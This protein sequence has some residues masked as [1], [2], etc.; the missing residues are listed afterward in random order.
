MRRINVR[1]ARIRRLIGRAPLVRR[2]AVP[3]YAGRLL[4]AGRPWADVE[5][6]FRLLAADSR[7]TLIAGP[8]AGG[9]S[10]ELLYW[11]PFLRWAI[12]SHRIDPARV[13]AVSP[14]GAASWYDGLCAT[15]VSGNEPGVRG[16]RIDAKALLGH[17]DR[18]RDGRDAL[19]PILRH[20][21]QRRLVPAETTRPSRR[22]VCVACAGTS[23]DGR[24]AIE[25]VAETLRNRFEIV[26][27]DTI[28]RDTPGSTAEAVSAAISRADGVFA[29]LSTLAYLGQLYGIPTI[30]IEGAEPSANRA[31]EEVGRRAGRELESPATILTPSQL[32][33]L[34]E[35]L[36][37]V[38][39]QSREAQGQSGHQ[40]DSPL[41]ERL[42]DTNP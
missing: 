17:V 31:D 35:L 16:V 3:W 15:F 34:L 7:L 25:H 5:R 28:S 14:S 8:W 24:A 1:S 22:Y 2:L 40:L 19:R 32:S 21:R 6:A 11:I 38:T 27:L 12:E 33:T 4:A 20:A 36:P 26:S 29:P 13:V 18:Y 23:D 9:T 42:L 30:A 39:G 41:D 10:E 37:P